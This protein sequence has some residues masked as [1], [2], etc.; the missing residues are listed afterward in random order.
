VGRSGADR[1]GRRLT[2]ELPPPGDDAPR[3]GLPPWVAIN[4]A[5]PD[6]ARLG[7][8]HA[9]L[10]GHVGRGAVFGLVSL[11][12]RRGEVQVDTLGTT[13]VLGGH[14]VTEDSIFRISSMSKPVTAVATLLLLE[15]CVPRMAPAACASHEV[16]IDPAAL[17]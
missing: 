6:L 5:A 14:P 3:V 15:E 12:A 2:P 10:D 13:A 16:G 17:A 4:A 1:A 8:L 9:V 7:H 11:A